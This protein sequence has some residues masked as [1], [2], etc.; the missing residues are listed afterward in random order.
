MP[1]PEQDLRVRRSLLPDQSPVHDRLMRED[2]R[3][4]QAAG[5]LGVVS[6]IAVGVQ[7]RLVVQEPRR[8]VVDRHPCR[9][10]GRIGFLNL[11]A[12]YSAKDARDDNHPK[13]PLHDFPSCSSGS[14]VSV[15]GGPSEHLPAEFIR[16]FLLHVLLAGFHRIAPPAMAETRET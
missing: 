8:L 4:E 16:R 2:Q 7:Y 12:H 13:Y 15:P 14:F 6:R 11:S 1:E 9:I 3:A 10:E 5:L